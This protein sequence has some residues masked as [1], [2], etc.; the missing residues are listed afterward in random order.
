[1]Q[2]Q[3]PQIAQDR[4]TA[5]EREATAVTRAFEQLLGG[6]ELSPEAKDVGA[7]RVKVKA[8]L[9]KVRAKLDDLA[10]V[11]EKDLQGGLINAGA[12]K[13]VDSLVSPLSGQI[14]EAHS[15]R[16]TLRWRQPE[17]PRRPLFVNHTKTLRRASSRR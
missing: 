13:E 14:F 2:S 4:L 5:L 17:R 6:F 7:E 11:L 3:V 12:E 8:A 10:V 15:R 9:K 1:L 16:L